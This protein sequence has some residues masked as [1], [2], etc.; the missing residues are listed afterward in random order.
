MASC[1]LSVST[2][3]WKSGPVMGGPAGRAIFSMLA[4]TLLGRSAS[5]LTSFSV[6]VSVKASTPLRR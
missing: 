5:L 4:I 6:E 1:V 3:R 2:A